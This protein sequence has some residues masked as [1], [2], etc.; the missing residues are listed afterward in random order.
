MDFYDILC[1][2]IYS[3][4]YLLNF[5]KLIFSPK[6]HGTVCKTLYIYRCEDRIENEESR[7]GSVRRIVKVNIASG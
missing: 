5:L 6:T 7:R 1:L 2:Y 4:T 3:F